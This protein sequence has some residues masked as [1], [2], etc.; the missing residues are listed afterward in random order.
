MTVGTINGIGSLAAG[1]TATIGPTSASGEWIIHNIY[2]T[3][4]ATCDI[5]YSSASYDVDIDTIDESMLSI[6]SHV[7][8][9]IYLKI[10]NQSGGTMYYGYDGIS[11]V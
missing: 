4:G 2:I 10:V 6:Y 3:D 1:A 9:T 8:Y 7:T 5:K 11:I